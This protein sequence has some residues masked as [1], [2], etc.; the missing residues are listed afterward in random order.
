LIPN[1]SKAQP[2]R[3]IN[4]KRPDNWRV[5]TDY[6]IVN[7]IKHIR[8]TFKNELESY[9]DKAL[10]LNLKRAWVP[11][12]KNGVSDTVINKR[13][14]THAP[15]VGYEIDELICII[16]KVDLHYS[17]FDPT[18][19]TNLSKHN[20]IPLFVPAQC[21]DA[22]Q[23]MDV[24]VNKTYKCGVKNGFQAHLHADFN[25]HL[26]KGYQPE[27]WK[28]NFNMG[29]LKPHITTFVKSGMALLCTPQ[30]SQTLRD[31]FAKECCFAEMRS[32]EMQR[33]AL[34]SLAGSSSLDDVQA[35]VALNPTPQEQADVFGMGA[36]INKVGHLVVVD[37]IEVDA[38]S[39]Y[40]SDSSDADSESD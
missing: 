17:H 22:H 24:V 34:A 2:K 4:L 13:S 26:A 16:L 3:W 21:T 9:T 30:F 8:E 10:A 12:Y 32:E 15:G 36:I 40:G 25:A 27:E 6:F 35:F 11:D 1:S 37:D 18:V 38:R 20:I 39:E 19:L 28:F 14:S 29:N 33:E 23:E 5:I 31:C 7:G